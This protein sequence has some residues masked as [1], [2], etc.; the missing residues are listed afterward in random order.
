MK[1]KSSV[2]SSLMTSMASVLYVVGGI[3][4][5]LVFLGFFCCVRILRE[6]CRG[7]KEDKDK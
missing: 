6:E 5:T 4:W 2:N 3:L 1:L 7:Q